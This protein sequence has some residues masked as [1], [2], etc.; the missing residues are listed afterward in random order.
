MSNPKHS[1]ANDNRRDALLKD[2]LLEYIRENSNIAFDLNTARYSLDYLEAIANRIR[3]VKLA[4][5]WQQRQGQDR[6][7]SR[8][9]TENNG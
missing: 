6:A 8:G 2:K 9:K 7:G 5:G 1:Q 3:G 4:S